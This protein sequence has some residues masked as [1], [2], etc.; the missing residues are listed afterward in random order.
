MPPRFTYVI[1]RRE[2]DT[3]ASLSSASWSKEALIALFGVLFAILCPLIVFLWRRMRLRLR[4]GPQ[5][6]E[7]DL[8]LQ[9]F[10]LSHAKTIQ[11]WRQLHRD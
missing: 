1:F 11:D 10:P 2:A 7:P 9:P 6:S 8:E 4:R 3:D 5:D